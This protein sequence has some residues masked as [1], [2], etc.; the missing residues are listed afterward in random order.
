M[1]VR[2]LIRDDKVHDFYVSSEWLHKR[3][4]ILKEN[5]YQCKLCKKEGKYTRANHVHHVKHLRNNPE[6]ALDDDNLIP[7][8]KECHETKCHPERLAKAKEPLTEERW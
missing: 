3:K 7:V 8:C 6:L 4:K 1:D 5:K 2:E